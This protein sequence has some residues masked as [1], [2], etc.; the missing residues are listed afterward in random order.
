METKNR[1]QVL[2]KAFIFA[3]CLIPIGA[4]GG[5]FTGKYAAASYSQEIQQAVI[6]QVGSIQMV[7][8]AAMVQ[9][10]LY[11]FVGGVI[12]YLAAA[13]IGLM[14]PLGFKKQALFPTLIVTLVCGVVMA[15]DYWTFGAVIPGVRALYADGILYKSVDNWLASVFYGGAIEEVLFRLCVM[16]VLALIIR[17]VFFRTREE[18][19]A[20]AI[21]AA[22]ILSAL[23]FA[24]GHLPTAVNMF[25]ALTPMIFFRTILLNGVLGMAYGWLYRKN[26]IQYAMVAHAGTH[27]LSKIIWLLLL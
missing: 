13:K 11:A 3:A 7:A 15:L 6:A 26:G 19:P 8:I 2:K 17:K 21:I 18:T 4:I 20:A 12:G 24:V 25:G 10:V 14:K 23:L 22:N 5:Y 16:S 1:K 27:I 9:S